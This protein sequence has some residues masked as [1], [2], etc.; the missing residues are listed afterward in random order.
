M[1]ASKVSIERAQALLQ[2]GGLV[3]FPTETVYGLGVRAD[4]EASVSRLYRVKGRPS[5]NPLI[6]HIHDKA[7]AEALAVWTPLAARLAETFWQGPLT[8][9]LQRKADTKAIV[10]NACGGLGTV[11][12]RMP[13]HPQA[14]ALLRGCSFVV[15]APSANRSSH[16]STTDA[17][18][19]ERELGDSIDGVVDGGTTPLGLESTIIDAQGSV[20]RVLR[21]GSLSP[22]DLEGRVGGVA[23][24]DAC[25]SVSGGGV[26]QASGMMARHYA[27]RTRM[28]LNAM[29][30]DD[31]EAVLLYGKRCPAGGRVRLNLS[32][33]GDLKEAAANF[34]R[35]LHE[36]DKTGC[37]SIAVMPIVNEGLGVALNDRLQRGSWRGKLGGHRNVDG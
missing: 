34:Y 19:V 32:A 10:D 4:D 27:P 18:D 2:A 28:R 36:L 9:V 37:D 5:R 7:Q 3:A 14:Q 31:N 17:R 21:W 1:T 13:S 23:W 33:Q 22:A 16:L 26:L 29:S 6:I 11:A 15:A 20:P 25:S 35:M 12:L 30:F 8:L 24:E